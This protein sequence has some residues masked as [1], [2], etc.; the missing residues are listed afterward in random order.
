MLEAVL[1][2]E[3]FFFRSFRFPACTGDPGCRKI[4]WVVWEHRWREWGRGGDSGVG[5]GRSR[6]KFL[7]CKVLRI[8]SAE[9]GVGL[10]GRERYTPW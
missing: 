1:A 10:F 6:A 2:V 7:P 5:Q 8:Y 9:Y 3:T 4:H